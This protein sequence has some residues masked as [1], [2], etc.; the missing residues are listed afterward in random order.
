MIIVGICGASGSGKSTLAR[1]IKDSLTCNAVIIGQDCY[2]KNHAHLP[3]EERMHINYDEPAVFDYDEMLADVEALAAGRPITR[4]GYDYANHM[5]ADTKERIF[6]PDVLILEGIHMFHDPRMTRE[7]SLKVYMHVDKDICLLR[8]I[9]RDF[10]ARGRSIENISEQYLAT[11]KPM[12]E[13]YI[14]KYIDDAD[15]A[16]M[17]GGKNRMA[18]DAISAYLSAKLLAEKFEREAREKELE[19]K[20]I[21]GR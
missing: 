4:K 1:E 7:M 13:Q 15:F 12:Y 19:E 8:R 10:P 9:K 17:R 21:E 6:P 18:I 11:V 5:R 3:F 20:T 14:S 2:Y 16:V